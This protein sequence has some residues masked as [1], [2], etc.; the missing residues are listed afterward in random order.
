MERNSPYPLRSGWS[1][2]VRSGYTRVA[3]PA[4]EASRSDA[5]QIARKSIGMRMI[6][7]T[8][9]SPVILPIKHGRDA[10]ATL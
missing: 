4:A 3:V 1:E 10:H 9:V 5:L 8:G 7:G 6:R 2:S